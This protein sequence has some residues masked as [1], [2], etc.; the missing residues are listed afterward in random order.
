VLFRDPSYVLDYSPAH[1]EYLSATHTDT[2]NE[3]TPQAVI[4]LTLYT[5]NA[6][7]K[8]KN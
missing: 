3:P 2:G 7:N 5:Y 4:A 8:E 1:R 6:V